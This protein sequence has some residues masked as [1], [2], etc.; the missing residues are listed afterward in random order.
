MKTLPLLLGAAFVLS[1]CEP[2]NDST[3]DGGIAF[4]AELPE[5]VRAIAATNQNLDAVTVDPIDNCYVYQHA[6]PVETTLLPLRTREGRPICI[7]QA[8]PEEAA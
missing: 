4:I 7:Q 3:T 2:V 1:A 6:G 5:A 8:E